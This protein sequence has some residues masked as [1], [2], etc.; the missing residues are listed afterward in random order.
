GY[1]GLSNA[2]LLAQNNKVVALDIDEQK[3]ALLKGKKSPI[4]DIEISD[5]LQN[6]QLNFTATTN[7]ES[8]LVGAEFVIIATPTDY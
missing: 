8:A 3:V 2:M 5:F 1:V 4:V 6:K 7:K